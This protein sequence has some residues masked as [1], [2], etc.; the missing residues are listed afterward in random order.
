M[1]RVVAGLTFPKTMRWGEGERSF[2]RP[3]RGVLA[4]YGGKIVPLE[5]FGVSATDRTVGHRVLSDGDFAVT[6][7]GR[8]PREAA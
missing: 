1:P 3:V 5:L 8:L 2:V 7:A 4:L 6:G